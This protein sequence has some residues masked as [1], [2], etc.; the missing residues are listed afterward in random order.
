M[1]DEAV[2]DNDIEFDLWCNMLKKFYDCNDL[3]AENKIKNYAQLVIWWTE[4][5]TNIFLSL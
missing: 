2:F 3:I 4:I 1:I 5:D